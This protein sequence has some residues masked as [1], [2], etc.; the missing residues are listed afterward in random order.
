MKLKIVEFFSFVLMRGKKRCSEIFKMAAM[1]LNFR[2]IEV[3]E[4][5]IKF[6]FLKK[7]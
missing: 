7:N 4:G 5:R 2:K 6:K 1:S 3:S